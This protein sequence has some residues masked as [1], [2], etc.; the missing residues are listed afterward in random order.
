MWFD[1]LTPRKK[2][3]LVVSSRLANETKKDLD[4]QEY[5]AFFHE[6]DRAFR[7]GTFDK[8]AFTTKYWKR[9]KYEQ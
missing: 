9:P 4:E 2:G 3:D 6:L 7:G 1:H 8:G 5:R